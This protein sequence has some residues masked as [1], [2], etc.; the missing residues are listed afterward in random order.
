[1]S[2]SVA[3]VPSDARTSVRVVGRLLTTNDK[4]GIAEAAVTLEALRL[5]FVVSRPVTDGTRYDLIVDTSTR[6]WRVQVKWAAT[7]GDTI[8]VRNRTV[9][10]ATGRRVVTRYNAAEVDA[11]AGYNAEHDLCVLVPIHEIED[12][13]HMTLRLSPAKNNQRVGVRMAS[14]YALATLA[15]RDGRQP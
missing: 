7:E 13:A 4:G 10:Q 6:L 11:I 12:A 5:G 15:K 14:A 9:R 8:V 1:M 3:V 2:N